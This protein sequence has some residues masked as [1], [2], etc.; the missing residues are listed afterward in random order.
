MENEYPSCTTTTQD[1]YTYTDLMYTTCWTR[2][3][4][5]I[6]YSVYINIKH[7]TN[8]YISKRYT[9][10]TRLLRYVFESNAKIRFFFDKS[11]KIVTQLDARWNCFDGA[12]TSYPY[13]PPYKVAKKVQLPLD[14]IWQVH[15]TALSYQPWHPKYNP[16]AKASHERQDIMEIYW[17]YN[18]EVKTMGKLSDV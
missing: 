4:F 15:L 10:T 18:Y 7:L 1:A 16:H 17:K 2:E 13:E 9:V 3:T 6:M 8:K 5:P 11:N 14:E 12:D